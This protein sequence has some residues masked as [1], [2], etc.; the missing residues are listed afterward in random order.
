MS[1]ALGAAAGAAGTRAAVGRP[2]CKTDGLV[3]EIASQTAMLRGEIAVRRTRI[4]RKASSSGSRAGTG[5]WGPGWVLLWGR[6]D[7]RARL[8]TTPP[9]RRASEGP[10]HL[11][12]REA[13]RLVPALPQERELAVVDKLPVPPG[14]VTGLHLHVDRED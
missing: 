13:C 2:R 3:Q 12:A 10:Q 6:L 8:P 4:L 5:C 7:Q 1:A 14:G 9:C 11:V